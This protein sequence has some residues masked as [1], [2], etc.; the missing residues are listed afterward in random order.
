M[1]NVLAD[2][3]EDLGPAMQAITPRQRAFVIALFEQH[4]APNLAQAARQAG[5]GAADGSSS[6]RV[7]TSIASR[8][9]QSEAIVAAI[10][11]HAKR[12]LRGSLVPQAI[13][14]VTAIVGTHG[15]KD[16]LKA[17]QCD[18]LAHRSGGTEINH[19]GDP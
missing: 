12:T 5:Y 18:P 19:G 4:G 6:A 7:M 17:A 11:E 8:L 13:A 14:A 9:A 3:K 1:S 15:D 2:D 10:G 16:R